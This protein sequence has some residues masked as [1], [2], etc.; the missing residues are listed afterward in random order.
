MKCFQEVHQHRSIC[1]CYVYFSRRRIQNFIKISLNLNQQGMYLSEYQSW[2]PF[3]YH[4]LTAYANK[5]PARMWENS[6]L[7]YIIWS[8]FWLSVGNF[9]HWE[10]NRPRKIC[11][12]NKPTYANSAEDFCICT[13]GT[14]FLMLSIQLNLNEKL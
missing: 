1:V 6:D 12:K 9:F 14:D 3:M 13:K 11:R 5:Y 2:S 4:L 7:V 8:F 10:E